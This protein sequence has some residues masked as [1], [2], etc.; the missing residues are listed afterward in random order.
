MC[1]FM[2]KRLFFWFS[3]YQLL[4]AISCTKLYAVHSTTGTNY[5]AETD[6]RRTTAMEKQIPCL[7]AP[8]FFW[9][10]LCHGSDKKRIGKQ[11][12]TDPLRYFKM[13]ERQCDIPDPS[14]L[15]YRLTDLR[16]L[17]L[18]KNCHHPGRY[19]RLPLPEQSVVQAPDDY[20]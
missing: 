9:W 4:L 19:W 17:L 13:S 10:L 6:C 18:Q 8:D 2:S 7:Y 3:V 5:R 1:L 20:D 14:F 12:V 11:F 16:L 15:R